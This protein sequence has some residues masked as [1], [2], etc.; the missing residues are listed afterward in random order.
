MPP[1]LLSRT[2]VTWF[3]LMVVGVVGGTLG[4]LAGGPPG[5]IA[6]LATALA[7]VGV[8][9]YNVDALVATRLE[10]NAE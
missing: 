5:Y 3:E 10:D 7:S 2:L 8:L 6:Y 4:S 1:R 9:L